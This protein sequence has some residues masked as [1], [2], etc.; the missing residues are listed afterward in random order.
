MG[1]RNEGLD[2]KMGEGINELKAADCF[3]IF[4][5]CAR[6][7]GFGM[8]RY[9]CGNRLPGRVEEWV[10]GGVGAWRSGGVDEWK[11]LERRAFAVRTGGGIQGSG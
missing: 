10:R 4:P 3:R 8:L 9:K 2:R 6:G 7:V 1:G 11:K 5:G